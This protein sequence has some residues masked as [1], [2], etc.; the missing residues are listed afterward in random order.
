MNT[1]EPELAQRNPLLERRSDI[2]DTKTG[3]PQEHS[4]SRGRVLFLINSL[5]GGGAERVFCALVNRIQPQ[6][7]MTG[8][9]VVLL[10]DK[11]GRYE[12]GAGINVICLKSTGGWL[13]SLRRFKHH[14]DRHPPKLVVSFLTRSNFLAVAF[15]RLY[16]YRC[17]ISERSDTDGRLG[18]GFG[19]WAKKQLVRAAY[20]YA[21]TIIAVS[22]GI[23]CSLVADYHIAP[24]IITAIHNPCDMPQLNLLAQQPCALAQDKRTQNGFILAVGR[25]TGTKRF[26]MLIR[27]YA[28]GNFKLPLV[29]LGEGPKRAELQALINSL[30]LAE[31]VLLPGF[32]SNPYSVM[33]RATVF[34]LSSELEG[35]PNSLVEAMAVGR[36]VIATNCHHGPSEI[37]DETVMP[38]IT[39]VHHGKYGMLVPNGDP[40][41]L[42]AALSQVLAD[43]TLQ[44]SLSE[45]SRQRAG[46]FTAQAIIGR[47]A[48]VITEQLAL[49]GQGRR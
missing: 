49:V 35:F 17:I 40:D 24:D 43:P 16:G 4:T 34:V 23:K 31:R 15:S 48:A 37:L 36:P 5:E 1:S 29:I 39:G 9:D 32:L 46:Q 33:A 26:D 28:L 41:A 47:Y 11:P 42:A 27:A 18:D 12:I 44:A 20:P 3:L 30:G 25:L 45:R 22:E 8:I 14:L 2:T 7:A 19:G 10:D 13:D 6:L 21:D 38:D